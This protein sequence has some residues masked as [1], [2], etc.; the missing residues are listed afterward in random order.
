MISDYR[1]VTANAEFQDILTEIQNDVNTNVGKTR[2]EV[3]E[4]LD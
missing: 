3:L 1:E 4:D 2:A